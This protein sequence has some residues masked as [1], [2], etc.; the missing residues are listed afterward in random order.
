M[1]EADRTMMARE[2]RRIEN[3]IKYKERM[4]AEYKAEIPRLDRRRDELLQK[5]ADDYAEEHGQ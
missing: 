3:K 2:V 5:I 1:A 4:I